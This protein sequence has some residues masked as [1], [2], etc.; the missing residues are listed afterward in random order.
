MARRK[1]RL[2]RVHKFPLSGQTDGHDG[3]DANLEQVV[4]S[5]TEAWPTEQIE[6]S[7]GSIALRWLKE[8]DE[9]SVGASSGTN[10]TLR[11]VHT[12]GHTEDSISL[13]LKETREVF[14][15]DT[16]LG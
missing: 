10:T 14:T 7:G 8:G 16:V 12:P 5:A 4:R 9:I 2:P 6:Q 11:V 3:H 13:V 1:A 15:G